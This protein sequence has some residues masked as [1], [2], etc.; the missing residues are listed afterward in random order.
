MISFFFSLI[1]DNELIRW[2]FSDVFL[3]LCDERVPVRPTVHFKGFW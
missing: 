1:F 3:I 2:L